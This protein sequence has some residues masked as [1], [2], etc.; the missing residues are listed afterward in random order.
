MSWPLKKS[1][2]DRGRAVRRLPRHSAADRLAP[3]TKAGRLPDISS[4]Y[5][6]WPKGPRVLG[7]SV[8]FQGTRTVGRADHAFAQ[9]GSK[10][11]ALRSPSQ[12]IYAHNPCRGFPRILPPERYRAHQPRIPRRA[13][14]STDAISER[15]SHRAP[16]ESRTGRRDR[17][18][19][20][21]RRPKTVS[22]CS[23]PPRHFA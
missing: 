13:G 5:P 6:C 4:E 3:Q 9:H 20:L 2:N 16:S 23:V 21:V 1:T 14:T 22:F 17:S 8:P 11:Y 19:S 15:T 10:A 12:S 18:R 7:S